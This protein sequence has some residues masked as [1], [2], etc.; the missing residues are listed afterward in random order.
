M[1]F[2]R[3]SETRTL[4][5]PRMFGGRP[6][7]STFWSLPRYTHSHSSA[8]VRPSSLTDGLTPA[9]AR[10]PVGSLMEGILRPTTSYPISST[11]A[12]SMV[13]SWNTGSDSAVSPLGRLACTVM[14]YTLLR[15]R[16]WITVHVAPSS[17]CSHHTGSAPTVTAPIPGTI[18]MPCWFDL[19]VAP[20][21][22]RLFLEGEPIDCPPKP[23]VSA[24]CPSPMVPTVC[25]WPLDTDAE[26]EPPNLETLGTLTSRAVTIQVGL[27]A[28]TPRLG[29]G[30]GMLQETSRLRPW[31]Q[32]CA[33]LGCA[34]QNTGFEAMSASVTFPLS[35]SLPVGATTR[36]TYRACMSV[37]LTSQ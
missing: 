22:F 15:A 17:M 14:A 7:S 3:S 21:F 25:D 31:P 13:V 10:A 37:S 36:K 30:V 33:G 28:S 6:L 19:S 16:P 27:H 4:E 1:H 29:G 20:P 11:L 12:A 26:S 32:S 18:V 34:S 23:D 2:R 24:D 8:A 5:R 35:I 9:A